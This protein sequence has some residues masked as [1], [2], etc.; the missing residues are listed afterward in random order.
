M[1]RLAIVRGRTRGGQ[2]SG[3]EVYRS[4]RDRTEVLRHSDPQ[5][6][7]TARYDRYRPYHQS[8]AGI[9]TNRWQA[10]H[11]RRPVTLVE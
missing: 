10:A 2:S 6:F 1:T 7:P 8:S 3:M 11:Q 9:K 4:N 5:C